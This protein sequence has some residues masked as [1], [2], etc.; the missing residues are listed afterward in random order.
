MFEGKVIFYSKLKFYNFICCGKIY[1]QYSIE[2][3]NLLIQG[4]EKRYNTDSLFR[5]AVDS[6]YKK[7]KELNQKNLL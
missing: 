4:T 7:F 2:N 3:D 6:L 1:L 5:I